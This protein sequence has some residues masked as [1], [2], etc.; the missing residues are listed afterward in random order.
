MD[1]ERFLHEEILQ[2]QIENYNFKVRLAETHNQ[3]K[4]QSQDNQFV[5]DE[6]QALHKHSVEFSIEQQNAFAPSVSIDY[7]KPSTV[8]H[9][10]FIGQRTLAYTH[11]ESPSKDQ[12]VSATIGPSKDITIDDHNQTPFNRT[13][14][15]QQHTMLKEKY[16]QE[17]EM[18]A[19]YKPKY[20]HRKPKGWEGRGPQDLQKASHY[21]RKLTD[22]LDKQVQE[23]DN[24][25]LKFAQSVENYFKKNLTQKQSQI[26]SLQEDL[27]H[28]QM[29]NLLK[30]HKLAQ[31]K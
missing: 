10:S 27:Q 9:S 24:D 22:Y 7:Q 14:S 12:Q 1:D 2:G 29:Q 30:S 5:Q 26:K 16:V 11:Q 31:K 3:C 28:L 6:I 25:P 8:E 13:E 19:M 17:A 23:C 4:V 15:S 21:N 20:M 18:H